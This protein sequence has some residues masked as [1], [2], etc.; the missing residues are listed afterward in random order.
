MHPALGPYGEKTQEKAGTVTQAEMAKRIG[1]SGL[2]VS[3]RELFPGRIRLSQR[4][5]A[6]LAKVRGVGKWGAKAALGNVSRQ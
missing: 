6:A 3:Q 5:L 1:V 4:T 2:L